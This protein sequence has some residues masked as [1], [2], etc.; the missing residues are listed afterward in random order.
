M[1]SIFVAE[2]F[3]NELVPTSAA[4]VGQ[5][6]AG[7]TATLAIILF[8]IKWL[9][10]DREK[11]QEAEYQA[12]KKFKDK[13]REEIDQMDQNFQQ[14][15]AKQN[16]LEIKYQEHTGSVSERRRQIDARISDL[17]KVIQGLLVVKAKEIAE[18]DTKINE[19]KRQMDKMEDRWEK[20]RDKE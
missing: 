18:F 11:L 2:A 9:W 8:G 5:W 12:D 16:I 10:H 13:M 4:S 15:L 6:F 20:H 1:I 19:L 17:E 14:L 3:A 7:G